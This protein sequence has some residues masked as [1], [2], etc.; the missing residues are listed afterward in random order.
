MRSFVR[1]ASSEEPTTLPIAQRVLAIPAKR[2]PK[3]MLGFLSREEI[4]AILD[5]PT[6][7]TRAGQ[8][9]RA[10]FLT[11]YNTGARELRLSI[12]TGH[13]GRRS[14]GDDTWSNGLV[15]EQVNRLI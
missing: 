11:L 7:T 13:S 15:E 8:R 4:Q 2:H 3:P 12:A 6:A 1:Y 5:A 14:G 9:D 10:L